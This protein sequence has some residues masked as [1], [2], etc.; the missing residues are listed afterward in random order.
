MAGFR[1]R[2]WKFGDNI[3]TDYLMP[4][5]T[6]YG[7]VPD[8]EKKLFC[9]KAIRPEFVSEV[10]PGDILVAGENF[11]CGSVRPAARNL[12]AL[13]VR[14]VLAESFGGIFF[15]NGINSG[16]FLIECKG[17]REAFE[18]GDE[19]EVDMEGTVTNPSRG[20]T[21]QFDPLPEHILKIIQA[22][23]LIPLLKQ[24][25][26]REGRGSEGSFRAVG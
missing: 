1:G 23:G 17:V 19:C 20:R 22:G 16:L 15:R 12:R 7:K 8:E 4:S 5:F 14:C 11:G 24:E 18:D 10:R 6:L 2:I 25:L 3:S 9:L 26:A 21:L 13:G